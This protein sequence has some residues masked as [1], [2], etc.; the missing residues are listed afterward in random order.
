MFILVIIWLTVRDIQALEF[1]GLQSLHG[2]IYCADSC[3]RPSRAII[4]IVIVYCYNA[5]SQRQWPTNSITVYLYTYG[6]SGTTRPDFTKFS[7]HAAC[8]HGLVVFLQR[9]NIMYFE[10]VDDGMFYYNRPYGGV[11]LQQQPCC[12]TSLLHGT[13]CFM[14]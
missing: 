8:D 5:H 14:F 13:G 11:T 6:I 9:C 7:V 10:F 12:I 4:K 3:C 2:S 1:D